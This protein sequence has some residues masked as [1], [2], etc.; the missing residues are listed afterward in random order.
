L[1]PTTSSAPAGLAI[2]RVPLSSL[3]LDPANA[4]SHG[5]ENLSAIE[6][7]LRRFGQAEPLIVHKPTGRIIGGNGRY[8]VMQKLAW[9]ECDII[10][11]DIDDLTATALSLALNRTS[12]LASWDEPALGKLLRELQLAGAIDGIGFGDTEINELLSGLEDLN[13]AALDDPGAGPLAVV[14]ERQAR[15]SQGLGAASLD[16]TRTRLVLRSL[17]PRRETRRSRLRELDAA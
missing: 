9:S 7:S 8:V 1:E 14:L 11:L 12:E 15:R 17:S 3:H 10:E 16:T 6:G 2:R 5:A 4:R 13:A